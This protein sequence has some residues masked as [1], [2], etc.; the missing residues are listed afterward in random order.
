[1][2]HLYGIYLYMIYLY[3]IY[4]YMIYLV[5]VYGLSV[6]DLSVDDLSIRR[7]ECCKDTPPRRGCAGTRGMARSHQTQPR[8]KSKIVPV[9]VRCACAYTTVGA[10]REFNEEARLVSTD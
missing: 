10:H 1:M 7:V 8:A 9:R 4:L 2:I 6:D 5:S 3:T